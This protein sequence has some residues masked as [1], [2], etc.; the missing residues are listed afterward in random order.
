ML[1][2]CKT[3]IEE[4]KLSK[5]RNFLGYLTNENGEMVLALSAENYLTTVNPNIRDEMNNTAKETIIHCH[6]LLDSHNYYL[7]DKNERIINIAVLNTLIDKGPIEVDPIIIDA[8][9]K[10]IE[11]TKDT[12][13]YFNFTIGKVS[14]L[15]NGKFFNFDSTNTLPLEDDIKNAINSVIPYDVIEQ[16]IILDNKS[17]TVELKSYNGEYSINLGAFSKGFV[18]DIVNDKLL[19][20]N[21][22]FIYNAGASSL[23]TYNEENENITW[24]IGIKEPDNTGDI[25]LAY[26]SNNLAISS[27]GDYEQ[28]FY[29]EDNVKHHHILDPYTGYSNNYYRSITL[30]S[31][32]NGYILDSLTTA[33]FNIENINEAIKMIDSFE[34]KYEM[35]INYCFIKD[36]YDVILSN[37]FNNLLIHEYLSLKIERLEIR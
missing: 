2:S 9:N 27:S 4:T 36:G 29:D 24:S 22:S 20:Y 11:I 3:E 8:L 7:N 5:E 34:K 16:Y 14:D 30:I 18:T 13:G 15:Y 28:Y 1:T 6:K 21:S 19:K 12:K 35:E 31:N 25:I 26:D 33:L 23:I 32:K 10:A 17:N 37:G